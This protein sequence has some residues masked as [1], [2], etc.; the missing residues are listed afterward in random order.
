MYI[1]VCPTT[2]NNAQY[3]VRQREAFLSGTS[4]PDFGGG[5]GES[6]HVDR[7]GRDNITSTEALQ[8]MGLAKLELESD[9]STG[10]AAAVHAFN[11][12]LGF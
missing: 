5:K 9:M 1:P 4:G 11:Q 6:E 3:L 2:E 12:A 10:Q 8:A 7:P